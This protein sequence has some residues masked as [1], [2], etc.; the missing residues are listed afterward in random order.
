MTFEEKFPQLATEASISLGTPEQIFHT[1]SNKNSPSSAELVDQAL[2]HELK[3]RLT[4]LITKKTQ[5]T[6][7][8]NAYCR[9]VSYPVRQPSVKSYINHNVHLARQ[10]A[11]HDA[12]LAAVLKTLRQ[13]LL[14]PSQRT[15]IDLDPNRMQYATHIDAICSSHTLQTLLMWLWNNLKTADVTKTNFFTG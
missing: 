5:R 11:V 8:N 1:V 15:P 12:I 6:L 13:H 7:I 3:S 2:Q 10:S 4:S 9:L 14:V